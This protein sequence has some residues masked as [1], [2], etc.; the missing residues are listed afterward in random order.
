MSSRSVYTGDGTQDTFPITFP[1]IKIEHITVTVNGSTVSW[2]ESAGSAVL[3]TPP[4]NGDSVV[5]QRATPYVTTLVSFSETNPVT[6]TALNTMNRQAIYAI[7]DLGEALMGLPYT[8]IGTDAVPLPIATDK[9]LVS[10]PD[11]EGGF[12]WQA[13]DVTEILPVLGDIPAPTAGFKLLGADPL[14]DDYVFYT[15]EDLASYIGG[16]SSVPAPSGSNR[17]LTTNAAGNDF[18]FTSYSQVFSGLGLGTAAKKNVGTSAGQVVE[19]ENIPDVGVGL[20]A[21]DGSQLTGIG[22]TDFALLEVFNSSSPA[23]AGGTNITAGVQLSSGPDSGAWV[24]LAGSPTS[25]GFILQSG[26]YRFEVE[27]Y[28]RNGAGGRVRLYTQIASGTADPSE[29]V[30]L[31]AYDATLA[32]LRGRLVVTDA[33]EVRILSEATGG[34]TL[35]GSASDFGT[36]SSASVSI[37]IW[38]LA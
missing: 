38:K 33:A 3:D 14:T 8:G 23:L 37:Q 27:A 17:F 21:V 34:G 10:R 32:T 1:Y 5:I 9:L 35:G 12:S 6:M 30:G 19:L 13:F 20:P 2:S 24:S 7:E 4:S 25:T 22:D 16:G 36:K 31:P 18:Q 11:G 26:T 15:A 29:S 28:T